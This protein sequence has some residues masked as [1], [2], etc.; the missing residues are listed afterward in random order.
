MKQG[1]LSAIPTVMSLLA[2]F[3]AVSVVGGFLGAGLLI[4]ATAV[5]GTVVKSGT[6]VYEALPTEFTSV[7]PQQ[8]SEL[9]ASDGKTVIATLYSE[10]R[11][12]VPLR[13]IS[14]W[15]QKAQ[16]SIEDHRFYEHGGV[17][18]EGIGSAVA[19]A[20]VGGTARGAS[21]L[22]QQYVKVTLEKAALDRGDTKAAKA[23]KAVTASRKLQ[24]LKYAAQ[25][26]KELTKEQI[27]QNYLNLVYFGD[28]A[29]GVE[30]AARHYFR[31]TAA[32]LTIPQA[33]TL[34]GVVQQPGA[35]DPVHNPKAA[36]ARRNVVLEAMHRYGYIDA[37]QLGAAKAT[38]LGVVRADPPKNSCAASTYP[39]W[40][41]YVVNYLK[42]LPAFGTQPNEREGRIRRGGYRIVTT[43]DPDLQERAAE[44]MG[45]IISPQDYPTFGSAATTI[46]SN[47]GKIRAMVQST[48]YS[49]TGKPEPGK[50][51]VNWGADFRYGASGGF[52]VGS[53]MK[54]F[55]VIEALKQGKGEGYVIPDIRPP[56]TPWYPRD[57]QSGCTTGAGAPWKPGNAEGDD[58]PP[59]ADIGIAT[60]NSINTAFVALAADIGTCNIRNTALAMGMHNSRRAAE[61]GS[62]DGKPLSTY[63]PTLLLGEDASP[64]TMAQ[65]YAIV[66]NR[67][68]SCPNTPLESVTDS[69]GNKVDLKLPGCRRVLDESIANQAAGIFQSVMTEGTG[70]PVQ[71]GRP[72]IGKTGTDA[73]NET[74]F[75]GATPQYATAVW[76]GTP[77]Q[78]NG[79]WRSMRLHSVDGSSRYYAKAMGYL[80][81]GPIWQ[82][83]MRAAHDGKPVVPFGQ[84]AQPADDG[85]TVDIPDVRGMAVDEATTAIEGA[86]FRVTVGGRVASG[87]PRGTV[88]RTRPTDRAPKGSTV[89]LRISTGV[90]GTP[91]APASNRAA[92]PTP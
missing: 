22:T 58:P 34:A 6:E 31:T 30:A 26:E 60:R 2:A 54:L 5:M 33:A 25:V 77:D 49:P 75:V 64:E 39:Y 92:P 43:I 17:D 7:V 18:L 46:E 51:Q 84:A 62:P 56:G 47:T 32:K 91:R 73:D 82:G 38:P 79:S 19:G 28:Q 44:S 86:G 4:P 40:C 55:A 24:E 89:T 12:V 20:L 80:I 65:M 74:W 42:T 48:G 52:S 9:L 90:R 11:I 29:Y 8:Q 3:L 14:P 57:F 66:A 16:V 69:D 88:A 68:I 59:G 72:S 67:G 78:N 35:N 85:R 87:Y 36:L 81:P 61:D 50:T 71:I 23:A 15:M 83:I 41:N 13:A 53:T 76:A 10:N 1:R 21:T 63:P 27:L 37:A 45:R 70:R